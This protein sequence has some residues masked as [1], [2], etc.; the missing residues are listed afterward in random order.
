M[1]AMPSWLETLKQFTLAK[2]IFCKGK[3]GSLAAET[4]INVRTKV[5]MALM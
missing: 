4:K 3:Y 5:M 2:T 1:L